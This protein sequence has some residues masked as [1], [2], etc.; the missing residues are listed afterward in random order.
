MYKIGLA[1]ENVK[2]LEMT[3]GRLLPW[4]RA[5]DRCKRVAIYQQIGSMVIG[6]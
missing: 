5:E 4:S 6:P 2:G 1:V 3:E